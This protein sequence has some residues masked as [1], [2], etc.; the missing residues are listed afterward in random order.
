MKSLVVAYG[1]KIGNKTPH[2]HK[3]VLFNTI[4][5]ERYPTDSTPVEIQMKN[6]V[7]KDG[8]H[9]FWEAELRQIDENCERRI[10]APLERGEIPHVSLFALGPQ[11]LLVKLG[12]V[13]NDQYPISVFQ[14][15]RNPDSWRWL[16]EDI[17]NEIKLI[18]PHEKFGCCLWPKDWK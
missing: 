3:D 7:M 2:F 8:E 5:P 17:Q 16:D 1:P 9:D 12:T 6:S 14:K 4:F 15:H 18:E 11:P 10:I 13:L